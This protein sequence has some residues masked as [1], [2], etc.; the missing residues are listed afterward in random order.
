MPAWFCGDTAKRHVLATS[1]LLGS[2][3]G[4]L[5]QGNNCNHFNAHAG[6]RERGA[7][8]GAR[9]R[10]GFADPFVPNAVHALEISH[11][12]QPDLNRC[13]VCLGCAQFGDDGVHLGQHLTGLG[14]DISRQIIGN[15]TGQKRDVADGD[16]LAHAGAGV[17]AGECHDMSFVNHCH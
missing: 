14:F 1:P 4:D 6:T 17:E 3:G 12:G 5:G 15:L 9:G 13:D 2:G 16:R 11:V 7:P 8:S 10:R